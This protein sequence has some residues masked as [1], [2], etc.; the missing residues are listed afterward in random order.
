MS[1]YEK[2]ASEI[3][4]A[5]GGKQNVVSVTHCMTRL[6]F[7]LKDESLA[8]DEVLEA[9]K[10]VIKV[11]HAGGQVQI[12]I[13][14][15][16]DK[17]YKEI[18]KAGN[19][20][21]QTSINEE[22]D[23]PKEPLRDKLKPKRIGNAILGAISACITPILPVFVVAGMFKMFAI[24]LGPENFNLLKEGSDS[25]RL[26]NLVAD[27]GYYFFPIFTAYSAS[28][29]FG[30]NPVL[31]L[32]L[33]GIMI[34]PEILGIVEAGQNFTVFGIPMQLVNYTKA[35]LPI[36]LIVWIMSGVEKWLQKV[37]PDVLRI[38]AI[39]VLTMFIMLPVAL[40]FLGP[41]SDTIMGYM[42]DFI[43]W[44][45]SVAGPLA[46]A[47]IGATWALIIATGMHVPIFTAM[48]PAIITVGYDPI[49]Y[50]GTLA[51]AYAIMA[52]AFVYSLRAKSKE[53]RELGWSTFSTYMLGRVSEPIIYG[54]LLRDRKA[55]AWYMIGG[56]SGGLVMGLLGANVHILTGVGF[57]IMN[58]LRFGP[59]IV[60]GTIGSL[61]AV[62][63]TFMLGM[64]FGFEGS[65]EN[66][67]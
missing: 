28:K 39:P 24:L 65:K 20:E 13:G 37:I 59:D 44:L 52:L 33:S 23:K 53:N 35:V 55:L 14:T 51:Q 22:L 1:N 4:I 34:H 26:L 31:A 11:I 21:I 38:V 67:K 41:L 42:A 6:R 63:V 45:A 16:V 19:F 40:C 30:A 18:C 12:V 64:I 9:I 7:V 43:I 10:G 17:V 54:I 60:S 48:L 3:L 5:V 2:S 49:L 56:F 58:V 57:P 8:K 27:S 50:P 46:T 66:K 62:G 47:V 32:L 15:T 61:V 29:K 36:I 25:L